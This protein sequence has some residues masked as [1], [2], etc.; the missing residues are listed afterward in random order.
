MNGFSQLLRG[1]SGGAPAAV[2]YSDFIALFLCSLV[3]LI[4]IVGTFFVWL[5]SRHVRR[6]K[7]LFLP[8]A[9]PVRSSWAS[10][11]SQF[12]SP[13][14]ESSCRWLAIRG[15]NP[16]KV[17]AALNLHNPTT[18]TWE[19]GLAEARD[20]KLFIS[21]PINGWILVVGAGLPDPGED[22]DVCFRF[23][24]HL[25]R[26]LGQV[27]FFNANRVLQH[28]TWARLNAGHVLRAYAWAGQT[29]W[30]QGRFTL[31]EADLG[32]RCF[33]Y[34]EHAPAADFGQTDHA[35]ANTEKVMVLA[36]RWSVDPA[37]IDQ[38]RLRHGHGIA[39]DLSKSY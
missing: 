30:N 28:H 31:L 24:S 26:K 39:G 25:S 13:L 12:Q 20:R 36:A 3:V 19:E 6:R 15:E 27:Q 33:D 11:Q 34:G 2:Q 14:F 1:S 29:V 5:A 16:Q 23:L 38:R 32:M 22:V 35:A 17:Q 10:S 9:G 7:L 4:A 37:A 21:P 8:E 18:C